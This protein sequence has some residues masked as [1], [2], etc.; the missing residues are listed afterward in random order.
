MPWPDFPAWLDGSKDAVDAS[1]S[2]RRR[3][4][5]RPLGK[6]ERIVLLLGM[7]AA[8]VFVSSLLVRLF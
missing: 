4:A 2:D 7:A 3:S 6:G 8:V 1:Q 5:R